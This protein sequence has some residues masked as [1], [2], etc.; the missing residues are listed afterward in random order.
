MSLAYVGLAQFFPNIALSL[1]AGQASDRFGRRKITG[2]SLLLQALC[3][4]ILCGLSS[5]GAPSVAPI[6]VLLFVIGIAR[7]FSAPAL[8]SILPQVVSAPEFA[9]AVAAAS[10][11]HQLCSIIGP[12]PGGLLYALSAP[13]L[14]AFVTALYCVAVIETRS[15]PAGRQPASR[16]TRASSRE[17]VT[18]GETAC[19]WR[20]IRWTFSQFCWAALQLYSR[21]MRKTFSALDLPGSVASDAHPALALQSSDWF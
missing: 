13:G 18:S 20:S 14:F 21:F 15:L 17:Y 3:A 1:L 12:A 10:S 8:P 2:L 16:R 11:A 9:R 4:A 7:A 5:T 6:Y 19:C